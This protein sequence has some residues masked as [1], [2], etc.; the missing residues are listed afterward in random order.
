MVATFLA[1]KIASMPKRRFTYR[2]V[3]APETIGPIMYLSRHIDHLKRHVHAAF[4][5]T[6]I[7][8][9]R[10]YSYI[11]SRTGRT[12]T[13]RVAQH[14]IKHIAPNHVAYNYLQRGSDER[15]Y[16]WPG[17]DLP[18]VTL[19]RTKFAV[20]PE[21]HTSLDNLSV[22][23]PEGLGG[24]LHVLEKCI[25]AIEANDTYHTTVL[26]EPQLG[27]RGLYTTLGRADPGEA[28][29]LRLDIMAYADG[30]HDLLDI[31]DIVGRPVWAL[32]PYVHE[33]LKHS[34]LK[35]L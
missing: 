24:G 7:G 14:V 34:L 18:M 17:V 31:A 1:R 32:V 35:P 5:L 19:M 12:Y 10:G 29:Q 16:G 21:Y 30:D 15:Q 26:C 28:A 11:A 22:I 2:F 9:D 27:K 23:T 33:L 4:N 6:C 8:D 20:Y 3:F 13:D 25:E